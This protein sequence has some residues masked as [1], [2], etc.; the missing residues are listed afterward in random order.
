LREWDQPT[1]LPI[2]EACL[3]NANPETMED[4]DV[5]GFKLWPTFRDRDQYVHAMTAESMD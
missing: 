3:R 1:F 2:V 4:R 5:E